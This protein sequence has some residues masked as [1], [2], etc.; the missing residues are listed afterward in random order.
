MTRAGLIFT[1]VAFVLLVI[2]LGGLYGQAILQGSVNPELSWNPIE[3]I[4]TFASLTKIS[5]GVKF[6]AFLVSAI[7]AASIWMIIEVIRGA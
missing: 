6:L 5:T 4:K 3:S 2:Y 7:I 1:F